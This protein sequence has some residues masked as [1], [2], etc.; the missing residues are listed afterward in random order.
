ME[1]VNYI[2]E[3]LYKHECVVVPGF[4]GF[5]TDYAP[6]KIH[7]ISHTFYPPSKSI[8]FNTKLDRNDGLL[9]HYISFREKISYEEAADQVEI[10]V[11]DCKAQLRQGD[12]IIFDKIGYFQKDKE[13]TLLFDPEPW[14]NYREESFG[15]PVFI[16]PPIVREPIHK[17][18]ERKFMD[19]KPV[20]EKGVK[21]QKVL[22]TLA[23][24]VPVIL[25]VVWIIFRYDLSN[26]KTQESSI[27][28]VENKSLENAVHS[29]DKT[30]D[31]LSKTSSL[32]DFK[33]DVNGSQSKKDIP[34]LSENTSNK[35]KFDPYQ[36]YI[37]GGAFQNPENADKLLH[38]LL[39]KGY[40]AKFAG[41]NAAGLLMVCYFSS[42]D[43]SEAMA[44]LSI[45]RRDD[46][47][48]AWLLKK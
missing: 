19:R 40:P 1:V 25:I 46:N 38:S 39:N 30:Q 33:F 21:R 18:L 22:T 12:K 36:Y 31:D 9:I 5:V 15:L 48:S 42:E 11:T 45:I 28:P 4:G 41:E 17:R 29:D 16:S 8:L 32:K 7:P 3:L 14:V 10:F 13:G 24:I 23:I 26:S 34:E 47:P 20:P 37:I 6:A 44:N 27:F 35:S 43:K 2:S